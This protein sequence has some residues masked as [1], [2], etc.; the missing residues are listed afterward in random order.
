MRNL[1]RSLVKKALPSRL[2]SPVIARRSRRHQAYVLRTLGI[3]EMAD[4][5]VK[6]HGLQVKYGPFSGMRY[7]SAAAKNRLIVPK[8]LGTYECELH[9]IIGRVQK[10]GYHTIVD[11]GC[12]EGYYTTGLALTTKAR[13]I[14]FDTE[15]DELK[16]AREMADANGVA[17]QI[18]F[19]TWCSAH[20][21]ISIA[22][23]AQRL[24][25]LS[26]CEGY[27]VELFND[28]AVSALRKADILIELHGNVKPELMRRLEKSHSL[29]IIAFN[30]DN[31]G[32]RPELDAMSQADRER[33]VDE[34]RF[35]QEWLWATA[36][37]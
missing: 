5:F 15:K 28:E 11:I 16:F 7:T 2:L 31:R 20:E 4:G 24:F 21:L 37:S 22:G 13:I 6:Q 27:E 12:G 3:A 33:A 19:R 18:S 10:A 29:K 17:A 26:D 36:K 8:L 32:Y 30:R 34:C 25:V 35:P 9:E 1:L 23:E 14:A